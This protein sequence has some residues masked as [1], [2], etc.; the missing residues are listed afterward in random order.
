MPIEHVPPIAF[1]DL[2]VGYGAAPVLH[3]IS[4]T[5]EEG[6]CVALTGGNGSGKSTLLKAL[7]GLIPH[8]AGEI[9]LFGDLLPEEA[10]PTPQIDWTKIGYV[11]QRNTIGGGV[12]STVREVVETGLLGPRQWWLPRGSKQKVD[13]VLE[14]VGLSSRHQEIFQVLSGGQQ[15]R[16]LIARAL[17]RRPP[18]LLLD[19]PLTGLDRHNREVLA[20]VVRGQKELGHTS[21]IVL[22]ELGELAP[23]IDHELHLSSGHITHDGPRRPGGTD[24]HSDHHHEPEYSGS[25]P[26]WQLEGGRS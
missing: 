17:V 2:E 25:T 7:L 12:G 21:L 14:I 4:A 8:S 26:S 15:Q 24:Q 22:H 9:H 18:L 23:L 1:H 16:T 10:G 20:E 5:V 3:D 19:E 13:R 11:P 6:S